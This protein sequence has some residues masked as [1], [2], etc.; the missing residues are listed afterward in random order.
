MKVFI[1]L[2]SFTGWRLKCVQKK[3]KKSLTGDTV[4]AI[5]LSHTV[6]TEQQHNT[7]MKNKTLL[8]AAAALVA[9]VVS[10]EAQVYSANVVGYA[11]VTL[12][13]GYNLICNPF[14]NGTGNNLTNLVTA[15]LPAKSSVTTWNTGLQIFNGAI[16]GSGGT[17]GANTV[18]PPGVGFFVKN[19]TVASPTVTNTF[20]GSVLAL[21]GSSVTNGLVANYT[22]VGSQVPY[23][24]VNLFT[25]PN[26]NL[27]N[28]GL[29]GKSSVTTWNAA[30]QIYNGAVNFGSPSATPLAV[31]QGFFIKS[32]QGPTNWVQTLP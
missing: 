26:V 19:G 8:I 10:S 29:A 6:N 24:A 20:V 22:L 4:F 23:A 32:V 31:G 2:A 17:W 30:S 13:G 7:K 21:A 28:S 18:I 5:V 11:N 25:D 3:V 14:D 1:F 15:N 16:N 27:V 12:V 9:G